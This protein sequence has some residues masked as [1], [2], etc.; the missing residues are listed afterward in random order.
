MSKGDVLGDLRDSLEKR[1]PE[2]WCEAMIR[3]EKEGYDGDQISEALEETI[4]ED[5]MGCYRFMEEISRPPQAMTVISMPD[6][7][8][9]WEPQVHFPE[10]MFRGAFSAVWSTYP[11]LPYED[12]WDDSVDKAQAEVISTQGV[13]LTATGMASRY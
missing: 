9:E 6:D 3:A 12:P 10:Q 1:N 7:C 4:K 11:R 8:E 13:F 5:P 2:K